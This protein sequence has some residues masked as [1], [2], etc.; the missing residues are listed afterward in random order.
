MSSTLG[1]YWRTAKTSRMAAFLVM[2]GWQIDEN[3]AEILGIV[4]DV[5]ERPVDIILPPVPVP[6]TTRTA[7]AASP[8]APMD[9]SRS[10]PHLSSALTFI[11]EYHET[12]ENVG[13]AQEEMDIV[14][15]D[16]KPE[17]TTMENQTDEFR[18]LKS[19]TA[20]VPLR[21]HNVVSPS[22]SDD[23]E[24]YGS[25]DDTTNAAAALALTTIPSEVP[26]RD[27]RSLPTLSSTFGDG[28]RP[29]VDTQAHP[30]KNSYLHPNPSTTTIAQIR[31]IRRQSG[32]PNRVM[33]PGP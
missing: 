22:L 26:A 30:S 1:T 15:L 10:A 27:N 16:K 12:M 21:S 3:L 20:V 8:S 7:M 29:S 18:T 6:K 2:I 5:H 33:Y 24:G 11:S 9:V 19:G 23:D 31:P 25:S 28:G 13:A 14:D 32:F 17:T 4:G